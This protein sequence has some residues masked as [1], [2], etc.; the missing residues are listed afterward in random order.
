M[1]GAISL[2][3]GATENTPPLPEQLEYMYVH[4]MPEGSVMDNDIHTFT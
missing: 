4:H 1:P 3:S 2:S